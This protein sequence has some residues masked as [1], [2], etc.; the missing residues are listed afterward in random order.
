MIAT[1]MRLALA[2]LVPALIATG[3]PAH[4]DAETE[5]TVAA[6]IAPLLPQDYASGL[7]VAVRIQGRTLFFN[8]GL[9]DSMER[10]PITSDALFNIGSIRKALEVTMLAQ[11]VK[12]GEIALD[13]PV[14]RYVAELQ[15]G[16]Y[17]HSVTL[18]QLAT[19]TSGFLFPTDHP[20]WPERRYSLPELLGALNHW[21]PEHGEQP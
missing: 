3:A 16:S 20:P 13:D 18:L 4:D 15:P 5:R 21:T 12:Q 11:A 8:Y 6:A 14:G 2:A 9:A 10:R 17:L 7:A 1:V 19:H